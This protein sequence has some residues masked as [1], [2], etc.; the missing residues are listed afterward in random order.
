MI[1]SFIQENSWRCVE[2]ENV[3]HSKD[4]PT[5]CY[6]PECP[7]NKPKK[8]LQ[9]MILWWNERKRDKYDEVEYA[10]KLFVVASD[11][12]DYGKIVGLNQVELKLVICAINR[13]SQGEH[14]IIGEPLKSKLIAKL[15]AGRK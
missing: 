14:K 15:E 12:G 1:M 2:C 6:K 7:S 4:E 8:T 3:Q 11:A 13:A 5:K 10:Q 9:Q